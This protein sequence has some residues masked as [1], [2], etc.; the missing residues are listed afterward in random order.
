MVWPCLI[1]LKSCSILF[2]PYRSENMKVS[3]FGQC[4][5]VA[6]ADSVAGAGL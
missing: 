6:Q 5:D 3:G 1:A 4:K 2:W